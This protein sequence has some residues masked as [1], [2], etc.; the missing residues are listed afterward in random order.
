MPQLRPKTPTLIS[1]L[2]QSRQTYQCGNFAITLSK[3]ASD[4]C[5]LCSK[6]YLHLNQA[7]RNTAQRS[8]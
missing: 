6:A 2:Q 7:Q 5:T 3:E 4:R 8:G 1:Q